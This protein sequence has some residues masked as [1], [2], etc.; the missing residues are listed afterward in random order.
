MSINTQEL[1]DLKAQKYNTNAESEVF[2]RAFFYALTRTIEDLNST[3]VGAGLGIGSVP[4]SLDENIS[5]DS[6]Y[7]GAV[8][9]GVDVYLKDTGEWGQQARTEV[10]AL[11]TTAIGKAQTKNL[12]DT[13]PRTRLQDAP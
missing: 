6:G 13:P 2:T 11:F 1:F 10:E 9:A 4:D 3:R 8:S 7:F 5:C 12:T